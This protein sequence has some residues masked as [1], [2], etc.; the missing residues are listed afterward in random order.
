VEPERVGIVLLGAAPTVLA[1]FAASLVECVE[2]LT[3]VLAVGAVRGWRWALTGSAAALGVL[4]ALI[5]SFGASIARVP[6]PVVQVAIGTL[7]L[8]FGLRWLRK[9]ILRYVGLIALHDEVAA[10]AREAEGLRIA[11]VSVSPAWDPIAFATAFKIVMLEGIEVVF[12]VIALGASGQLIVPASLGAAAALF[13]VVCLGVALHRPLANIPENTLKYAV[14]LLLCA[15]G[16]FWVGEGIHLDWPAADWS[17][18]VLIVFYF[19]T[20]QALIFL[21]RAQF[22]SRDRRSKKS[23]STASSSVLGRLWQ[24]LL[25][26]FV[27]DHALAAGILAW[28]AMNWLSVTLWPGISL[29][30]CA[31]FAAGI[32][33][34]LVYS[35][36]RVVRG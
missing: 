14:G 21:A 15:F 24:E 27:D 17:L 8:M 35:V 3:I 4:V 7:L 34:L 13:V 22:R 16:C 5:V 6:L 12:I 9:A 30:H 19:V 33:L 31:L 28:I 10:Y 25:S 2:A 32:A 23:R 36:L 26:L 11:A 20:A 29:V 18:V 1:S